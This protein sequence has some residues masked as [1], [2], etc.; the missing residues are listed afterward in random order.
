MSAHVRRRHA[1]LGVVALLLAVLA[2]GL[3][4]SSARG[5]I[6]PPADGWEL[7]WGDDFTGP[8]RT[9]PSGEKWITDLGHSYPGGPANWGTGEIQRYT[10]SP[11]N[12]SL[13]GNGNLRITPLR[14]GAGNWTSG[15]IE[16][17]RSDFK[18][19]EDGTLR[20]E[21]R[22]RMPDVAGE[23]ALG[24]WSAFWALGSPYRGDYWNWPGIGEFDVMENVNGMNRV[25]GVLHC[26]VAPGGPC[27][28]NNGLGASRPCPGTSCQAAFHT[29]RFEWD[30]GVSP[31]ELRWYVDDQ[32]YHRLTQD[33]FD[34][35]TWQNMTGHAGYFILLNVAMGGGFPD[36]VAGHATPTAATEPGHSMLVDYVGVWT[37]GGD[38]GQDPGDPGEPTPSTLYLRDGGGLGEAAPPSGT[39]TLAS[40]DGRNHDGTPHAARTFTARG[41]TGD[42]TGGT[43]AFDLF[44]DAGTTVGNGQQVR[45][46]YDRTGDGS[47]ERSETYHY[48]ATDPVPGFEHYTA[49]RG[50]HSATGALGDM[51]NGT[52]RVEVWN[53]I[54]TGPSTLGTGDR[55]VLHLPFG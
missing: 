46:S 52:V 33:Q 55:S 34:A 45:I 30:R 28:E 51:V 27:D 53:A 8:D 31:N 19:P 25:W 32:L 20:I 5:D 2:S 29:Y 21:S 47:W 3:G 22:L 16:T 18:A 1:L 24:Y 12:L 10:D 9:P 23:Q 37:R 7:Q 38:G 54:G 40:A 43:T 44:V 6:P 49:E 36:G 4:T 42:Y 17:R 50:L 11:D 39:A 41:V 48:F 13:D 14:D 35:T 26:G 15:R